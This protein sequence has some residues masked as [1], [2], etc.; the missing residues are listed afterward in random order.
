MVNIIVDSKLGIII[1]TIAG[2]IFVL[3]SVPGPLLPSYSA[4]SIFSII[5]IYLSTVIAGGISGLIIEG[6]II[7]KY[8]L[9]NEPFMNYKGGSIIG[10]IIGGIILF[11]IACFLGM[12]IGGSFGFAMGGAIKTKIGLDKQGIPIIGIGLAFGITFV[13]ICITLIGAV[14]GSLLGLFINTLLRK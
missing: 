10:C 11:P 13:I 7:K 1:G 5:F 9:L 6:L 3:W 2:I 14:I 8:I 4:E 12:I